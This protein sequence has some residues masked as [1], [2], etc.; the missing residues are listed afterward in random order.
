M[1]NIE[2]YRMPD[3]LYYHEENTWVRI[4][5][6]TVRVGMTDF[7]QQTVG[8][9]AYVELPF[10]GDEIR[11]GDVIGKAQSNIWIRTLIGP[12]SG[13]IEEVNWELIRDGSIMNRDPY[14]DGWVMI[15]TPSDLEDE[16]DDLI[17]GTGAVTEWLK[18]Q[19]E[20][21]DKLREEG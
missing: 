7:F 13:T 20:K 9:I 10:E 19:I 21:V 8:D 18:R 4:E 16:M 3:N 6:S 14:G 5:G 15:L 12:L 1:V 2:G 11:Q 17:H